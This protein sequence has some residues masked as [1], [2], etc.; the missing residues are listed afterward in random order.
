MIDQVQVRK[1]IR[2]LQTYSKFR[3]YFPAPLAAL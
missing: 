2:V 1:F 3:E